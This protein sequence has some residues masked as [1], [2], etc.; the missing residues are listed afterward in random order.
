[1]VLAGVAVT[2]A[3]EGEAEVDVGIGA[4][5]GTGALGTA[6]S[7]GRGSWR[8]LKGPWKHP[9][10]WRVGLTV[11]VS[12]SGVVGGVG[13]WVGAW[14]PATARVDSCTRGGLERSGKTCAADW[15][16]VLVRGG[17]LCGRNS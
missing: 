2:K 13:L 4:P 6:V 15:G 16:L 12:G 5:G 11:G 1:M 9:A 14:G 7:Y 10:G 8:R 3:G 17:S